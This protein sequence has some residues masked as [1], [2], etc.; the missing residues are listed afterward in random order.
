MFPISL[1]NQNKL[2]MKKI[3]FNDE[4]GTRERKCRFS[5]IHNS[6]SYSK[7]DAENNNLAVFKRIGYNSNGKWSSTTWEVSLNSATLVVCMRPFDG[8]SDKLSDCLEH[9]VSTNRDYTKEEINQETALQFFSSVYPNTY[10][11]ICEIA[12]LENKLI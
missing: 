3:T 4:M 8:W 11:K 1:L 12:E 5:V 10:K 7:E 9:I 2:V 6:K